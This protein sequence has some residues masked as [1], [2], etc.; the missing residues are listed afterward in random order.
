MIRLTLFLL[1]LPTLVFG[2]GPP[3]F[4]PDEPHPKLFLT[5]NALAQLSKKVIANDLGWLAMK[6]RADILVTYAVPAYNRGAWP[7]NAIPYTYQGD[8]WLEAAQ[9]L[10]LAYK[11]TGNTA[12]ADKLIQLSDIY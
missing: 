1:L 2:Y 7:S 6:A 12:Y 10:G 8:S 9:V 3:N 11:V 5:S 4:V